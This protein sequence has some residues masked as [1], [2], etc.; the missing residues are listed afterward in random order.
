MKTVTGQEVDFNFC[1]LWD[2]EVLVSDTRVDTAT[3]PPALYVYDLRG[4]DTDPGCP[5]TL[6]RSVFVNHAGTLV[7]SVQLL[8]DKESCRDI[9]GELNYL[10]EVMTLSTYC[11]RCGI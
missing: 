9:E 10:G 4:S 6:E 11:E 1:E 3:V 2:K 5:S 7:S 8:A